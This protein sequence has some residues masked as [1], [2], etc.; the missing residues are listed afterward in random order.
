MPDFI[1]RCANRSHANQDWILGGI[2]QHEFSLQPDWVQPGNLA[3]NH[4]GTIQ[5]AVSTENPFRNAAAHL[6]YTAATNSWALASPTPNEFELVTGGQYVTV[7]CFLTNAVAQSR[8][9][10]VA[11]K[12]TEEP[13]DPS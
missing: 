3:I 1:L 6:T 13:D 10:F 8:I 11:G 5:I 2:V 4:D 7:R 9:S 12:P